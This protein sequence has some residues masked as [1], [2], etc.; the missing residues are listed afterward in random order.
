MSVG[1]F[2]GVW[3]ARYL[4]P[5]GFGTLN[6]AMAIFTIFSSIAL[7][8]LPEIIIR[9]LVNNDNYNMD[10]GCAALLQTIGGVAAYSFLLIYIFF[11]DGNSEQT[12]IFVAIFGFAILFKASEIS[13]YWFDSKI[14]SKYYIVSQALV[15]LIFSIVKIYLIYFNFNLISFSYLFIFEMFFNGLFLLIVLHRYGVKL[16]SLKFNLSYAKKLLKDSWPLILAA[17]AVSVYMKIDQIMLGNMMG[18]ES[19]GVYSAALRISEVFYFLP[20]IISNTFFPLILNDKKKNEKEYMHKMQKLY[21][22]LFAIAFFIALSTTFLAPYIVNLLYGAAYEGAVN[23]LVM[24]VWGGIFVFLGVASSK[25]IVA[26]NL[27]V[28]ALQRTI[29]GA[30]LNIILNYFLIPDYGVNGAAF[31]TLISQIF[32]ALIFDF[33]QIK[34]RKMFFMKLKSFNLF[35]FFNGVLVR[36]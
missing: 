24:H 6:Y 20:I 13:I 31:A 5:E 33:F 2:V 1:V 30:I 14:K 21:D 28:Y 10:L 9:N 23:V 27:Q 25:W 3:L 34:T 26:E 29:G 15:F 11:V 18:N 19:V 7:L 36:K 35:R 22:Y 12:K 17:L 32:S 4:G 8:G 16:I